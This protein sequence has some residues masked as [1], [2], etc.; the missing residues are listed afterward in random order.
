MPAAS[1]GATGGALPPAVVWNTTCCP[2][3]LGAAGAE[4]APEAAGG[5]TEAWAGGV[6]F[7]GE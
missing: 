2:P 5:G 7:L 4:T 3:D 6:R 1:F